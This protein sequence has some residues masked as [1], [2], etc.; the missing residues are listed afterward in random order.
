MKVSFYVAG[1]IIYKWEK[2][3][4]KYK[5]NYLKILKNNILS[6]SKERTNSILLGV[7]DHAGL[8]TKDATSIRISTTLHVI[9]SQPNYTNPVKSEVENQWV[10][11]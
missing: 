5:T 11:R 2:N 3:I 6:Y 9:S 7:P 10:L 8:I 1:D 4:R